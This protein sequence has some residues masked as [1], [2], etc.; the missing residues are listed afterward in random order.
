MALQLLPRRSHVVALGTKPRDSSLS[1]LLREGYVR[2]QTWQPKITEPKVL[3]WPKITSPDDI[4]KQRA[5]FIKALHTIYATGGRWCIYV[6]EQRYMCETLKLAHTMKMLL[7]QGR[8]LDL[9]LVSGCQRPAFVPTEIY[10]QATHLFFWRDNDENN[11]KRIGGIGW[12]DSKKIKQIVAELPKYHVLY[13]NSREG[14]M[15]TT[16]VEMPHGKAS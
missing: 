16:K 4:T 2:Q 8:A 11:L 14:H 15:I 9:S 10:D 12:L 6:D 1:K 3:L 7:M 5:V 13:L